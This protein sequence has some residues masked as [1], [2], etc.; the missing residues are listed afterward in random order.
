MRSNYPKKNG[1]IPFFVRGLSKVNARAAGNTGSL[2][3][4]ERLKHML[5]KLLATTLVLGLCVALTGCGEDE[6]NPSSTTPPQT[7]EGTDIPPTGTEPM[8]IEEPPAPDG[9]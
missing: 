8:D 6:A 4:Q 7:E 2:R 1:L 3:Q 5:R 9:Q